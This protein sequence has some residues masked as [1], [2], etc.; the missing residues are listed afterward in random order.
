MAF[1]I[2]PHGPNGQPV[3]CWE[4]EPVSTLADDAIGHGQRKRGRPPSERMEAV[5]WLREQ[6]AT[7]PQSKAEVVLAGEG[8]GFALRTLER[9]FRE[10]GGKST[11]SGFPAVATW[12]ASSATGPPVVPA[13]NNMAELA[14]LTETPKKQQHSYKFLRSE[15]IGPPDC[16]SV[17]EPYD[18]NE[19]LAEFE[20]RA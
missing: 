7:G 16:G 15:S 13:T 20:A 2:E 19:A 6:L 10:I 11:Q 4:R 12:S 14:E 3:V 1:T 5:E 18:V 8:Y 9:A 17:A